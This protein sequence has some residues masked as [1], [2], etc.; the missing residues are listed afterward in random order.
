MVCT[1]KRFKNGMSY[2]LF[3]GLMSKI[4]LS[5]ACTRNS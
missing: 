2:I 4:K 3:N 5:V 1:E